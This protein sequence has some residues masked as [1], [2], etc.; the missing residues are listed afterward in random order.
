LAKGN[1]GTGATTRVATE[2]VSIRRRNL[3]STKMPCDG[4]TAFGNNVVNVRVLMPEIGLTP[5]TMQQAFSI[6][7]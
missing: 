7:N 3:V 5:G 4:S 1:H 6:E 2:P